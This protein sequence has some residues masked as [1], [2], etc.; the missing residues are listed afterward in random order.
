MDASPF[1]TPQSGTPSRT[2]LEGYENYP[3][4]TGM[5]VVL[6]VRCAVV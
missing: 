1:R 6:L 5:C 4:R 2:R 3:V